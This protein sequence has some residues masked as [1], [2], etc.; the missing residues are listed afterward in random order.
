MLNFPEYNDSDSIPS[1]NCIPNEFLSHFSLPENIDNFKEQIFEEKIP[2]NLNSKENFSSKILPLGETNISPSFN[3]EI[4]LNNK[5]YNKHTVINGLYKYEDITQILINLNYSNKN[6]ILDN[7]KKDL[8]EVQVDKEKK[9]IN[10]KRN[11]SKNNENDVKQIFKSKNYKMGRKTKN[12]LS[13]RKH[14][15]F[16]S[17]NIMRKIKVKLLK[18][19]VLY[20]NHFIKHNNFKL[21]YLN[22]SITS[23]LSK[24][25]ELELLGMH[26]K[27]LLSKNISPK[28]TSLKADYN[29]EN[30]Q[31]IIKNEKDN[32]V[33]MFILNLTFREWIDIFILK[34]NNI[35]YGVLNEKS[36]KDIIENM[37]KIGELMD[38]ILTKEGSKYLSNFLFWLYNYEIWFSIKRN[39]KPKLD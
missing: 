36:S 35:N 21:K 7:F 30:I 31:H 3:N 34:K 22:Y 6:N 2:S 19:L 10:K 28:F 25:K 1:F 27:D 8:I 32:E 29:K 39:R 9:L 17:D 13:I 23:T 37:P 4:N 26:V 20:T 38:I 5:Q 15:K 12:D 11:K 18:Y 24:K 14:N 16:N 33:L